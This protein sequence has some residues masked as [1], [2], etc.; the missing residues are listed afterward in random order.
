[1][2][3]G[4]PYAYWA[5]EG[6][7]S[8]GPDRDLAQLILKTDCRL[9][10]RYRRL[11][12]MV[13]QEQSAALPK[14]ASLFLSLAEVEI[15]DVGLG[16]SLESLAEMLRSTRSLVVVLPQ[17]AVSD[18][19][20]FG[21]LFDRLRGAGMRLAHS[22]V[23]GKLPV[24]MNQPRLRPDYL[25]LAESIAPDIHRSPNRQ[26]QAEVLVRAGLDCGCDVIATALG[27]RKDAEFCLRLGCRRGHGKLFDR[28]EP[29]TNISAGHVQQHAGVGLPG[30]AACK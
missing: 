30:E 23:V 21:E 24:W 1:L 5:R 13:A 3:S 19:G 20:Y 14:P 9:G 17:R 8:A 12:R 15:G 29:E 28:A 7:E 11:Q 26:R 22:D 18:V 16:R 4:N 6:A 25:V 2:D 10:A 27:H